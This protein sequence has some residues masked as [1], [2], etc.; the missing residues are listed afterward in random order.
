MS[1]ISKDIVIKNDNLNIND[2]NFDSYTLNLK[3]LSK[4]KE[5]DKLSVNENGLKIEGPYTLQFFYRYI[6]SDSRFNTIKYLNIFFNNCKKIIAH[7]FKKEYMN[8]NTN[9]TSNDN[10]L[11]YLY[12]RDEIAC[13]KSDLQKTIFGLNNLIKTYHEDKKMSDA[14]IFL[15]E[16][17][18]TL[19]KFITQNLESIKVQYNT[20]RN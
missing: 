19:I 1:I 17:I 5:G 14:I 9:N 13:F 6:N 18:N 10:Y 20:I 12:E 7:K 8:P 4:I 11:F 15:I 3:I 16:K 2:T